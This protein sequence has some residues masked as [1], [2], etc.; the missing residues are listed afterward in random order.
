MTADFEL[1]HVPRG[2]LVRRPL[3]MSKL[4]LI[5]SEVVV[6]IQRQLDWKTVSEVEDR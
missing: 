6:D 3:N 5:S 4:S 1:G 2:V